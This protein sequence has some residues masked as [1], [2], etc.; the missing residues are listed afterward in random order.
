MKQGR[1]VVL[2]I[3][4][5]N[6]GTFEHAFAFARQMADRGYPIEYYANWFGGPVKRLDLD[7][8][9]PT[10]VSP[11]AIGTKGTYYLQSHTWEHD[12]LLGG[13]SADSESQIVMNLHA[14][15]PY[16]YL[17]AHLKP[18][19]LDGTLPEGEMR[20]IIDFVMSERERSQLKAIGRSNVLLA[21]SE[22]HKLALERLGFDKRVGV[23]ENVSDV[24]VLDSEILDGARVEGERYRAGLDSENVLLYYGRLG[25]GKRGRELFDA[26]GNIME[27]H[28]STKLILLGSGEKGKDSLVGA[29]L[30]PVCWKEWFWFPGLIRK[31]L[32]GELISLRIILLQMF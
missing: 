26:F 32:K 17:S 31:L 24:S 5:Q 19:F 29:G 12:G 23:F 14:V 1:H 25:L 15:I 13:I 20:Q 4:R 11:D 21:I 28:P 27:S 30:N 16:F 9:K 10:I 7:T 3:E 6:S 8:E 18:S 22:L 2:G